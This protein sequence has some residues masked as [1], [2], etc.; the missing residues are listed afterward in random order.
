M[1]TL[2]AVTALSVSLIHGASA[3][4]PERFSLAGNRVAVFNL[5]GEVRVERGTGSSVVVEVLRGGDDSDE[6]TVRT[7]ELSD[8][9]TLRVIYPSNR[10][11]Y[12]RLGRRS[13]SNFNVNDD[14]TFGGAILHATLD[15]TGFHEAKHFS[16]SI[17]RGDVRVSGNGSGLEAWADLRVLV[18]AGQ[19]VAVHLG[20]GKVNIANVN[21]EIRVDA[22]SGSVSATSVDG[23]MLLNTGSGSVTVDG[24]RGHLRVSTGSGGVRAANVEN[25]T[26]ILGT[27]SGSIEAFNINSIATSM[28]TGSGSIRIEDVTAPE[29]K[30]N[31][32]S[33]GITARAVSARDLSLGTGSGSITLELTSDVRNARLD[34]GSG[35]VTLAVPHNLGAELIVDTGSGG[36]SSDLPIQ[37]TQQKRSHLRGRL[38]D[39]NGRIEIDTGSGG[40]RLRSN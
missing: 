21:G 5:A 13:R 37:I 14:G 23:A 8:W 10:I 2:A 15:E 11:V 33:G 29:F 18:P 12:P 28:H 26:V 7:G 4:N 20:V 1:R 30:L 34:T 40:V 31:T 36:I 24:A 39:G 9:R 3:Q 19:T 32:G 22:R 16:M 25:G 6:L 38:G 17:G 35:S 27:G